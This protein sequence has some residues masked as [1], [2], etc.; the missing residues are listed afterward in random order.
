MHIGGNSRFAVEALLLLA[1][2]NGTR[3]CTAQDL[4]RSV[5]RSTSYMEHLMSELRKAGLVRAK[6]GPG[7]G[8]RLAK[9][10]E[11]VTVAEVFR[12]FDASS[13]SGRLAPY[14]VRPSETDMA[15]HTLKGRILMFLDGVSLADIAPTAGGAVSTADHPELSVSRR[16]FAAAA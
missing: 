3:R 14:A 10:V 11:R 4:A 2:A 15:W 9:D 8:Y 7:G 6:R 1:A 16:T 13:V 5:G 12:V